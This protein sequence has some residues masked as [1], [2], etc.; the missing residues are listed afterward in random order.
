MA[1]ITQQEWLNQNSYR[2]YPFKEDSTRGFTPER[3]R[4]F[5]VVAFHIPDYLLVDMVLTVA[6]PGDVRVYCE[7]IAFIDNVLSLTFKDLAGSVVTACSVDIHEHTQY[8]SYNIIGQGDYSD[9]RGIIVLGE[10]ATLEHDLPFGVYHFEPNATELEPTVVHPDIRGVRAIQAVDGTNRTPLLT[11]HVKLIAGNNVRLTYIP[12]N[13][14]IR[15]DGIDSTGFNDDCVCDSNA[16][17]EPI[18]TINGINAEDVTIVGGRCVQVDT[19]GSQIRISDTC[20]V[21]CCGCLELEF[22]GK[23]VDMLDGRITKVDGYADDIQRALVD[24]T[25]NVLGSL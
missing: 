12:E 8:N 9:A 22:L 20:S 4:D 13:N 23:S 2:A 15:I 11:G 3:A 14:A 1:A 24:F 7:S 16:V 6:G 17:R 25:S 21:P 18:T 19:E 10:L 5:G